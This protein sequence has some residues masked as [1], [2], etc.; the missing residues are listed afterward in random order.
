[1]DIN[2]IQIVKL[3]QFIDKRGS[4]QEFY[5]K[6]WFP[7]YDHTNIQLNNSFSG[8]GVLRGLHYHYHQ[9]DYWYVP[10]GKLRVCL[11]DIRRDS[12]TFKNVKFIDVDN[13]IGIFIPPGVAHGFYALEDSHLI[14]V[15]NQYYDAKDDLGVNWDSV[16]WD[17]GERITST[18]DK[19]APYINEINESKLIFNI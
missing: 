8:K 19:I 14:Y 10:S 16:E 15:V 11:F 2:D 1:M 4:F 6:E 17:I 9:Y 13:T 12:T 18:R 7:Q 5:R 3:K